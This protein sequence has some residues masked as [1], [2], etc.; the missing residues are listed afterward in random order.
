MSTIFASS[1]GASAFSSQPTT[2]GRL[3][4]FAAVSYAAGMMLASGMAQNIS[5]PRV[6]T[7]LPAANA[8][9]RLRP[10]REL[11]IFVRSVIRKTSDAAESTLAELRDTERD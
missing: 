9:E 3:P 8:G 1:G 2:N 5:G 4:R 6:G 7:E 11:A 10:V